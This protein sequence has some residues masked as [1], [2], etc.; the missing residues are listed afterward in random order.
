ML[1]PFLFSLALRLIVAI[2]GFYFFTLPYSSDDAVYNDNAGWILSQSG[3]WGVLYGD[4]SRTGSEYYIRFIGL[5]YYFIGRLPLVM[6]LLN[7]LFGSLTVINVYLL[8]CLLWGKRWAVRCAWITA[9][10]PSMILLSSVLL[11]EAPIHFLSSLGL[12]YLAKFFKF[13]RPENFLGFLFCFL[14]AASL[15]SVFIFV[16]IVLAIYVFIN[17]LSN[18]KRRIM[19][20]GR[21]IFISTILLILLIVPLYSGFGI[22]KFARLTE[23]FHAFSLQQLS[24]I[25]FDVQVA[26]AR[27]INRATYLSDLQVSRPID[28]ILHAPIRFV[29]FLFAPFP[30]MASNLSD[31]FGILDSFIYIY[32]IFL[33]I[34]NR[35]PLKKRKMSDAFLIFIVAAVLALLFLLSFSTSN[36][37]TAIRH[38]AKLVVFLLPLLPGSISFLYQGTSL[39][40]RRLRKTIP[41]S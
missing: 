20:R 3:F 12:L 24:Q 41:G 27:E 32:I 5:I 4:V 21:F 33:I 22:A 13:R 39:Y 25:I 34:K 8:S 6:I 37:G 7:V 35:I 23:S 17:Q 11:R 10:F 30:W 40:P 36:Y 31:L 16:P 19:K 15:H 18:R 38:R 9:L 1:K 14:V 26:R 2:L 29:Y 28:L